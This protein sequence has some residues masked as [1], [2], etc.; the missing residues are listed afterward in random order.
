MELQL[1][2]ASDTYNLFKWIRINT[3]TLHINRDIIEWSDFN[4]DINQFFGRWIKA[5]K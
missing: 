3:L 2:P 1:S 5:D 4:V